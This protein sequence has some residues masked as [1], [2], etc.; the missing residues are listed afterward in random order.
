MAKSTEIK[1]KKNQ[2][3]KG[4]KSKKKERREKL[5]KKARDNMTAISIFIH[6]QWKFSIEQKQPFYTGACGCSVWNVNS[7]Q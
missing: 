2:T 7:G 4:N 5:C 6:S 3:S 1:P